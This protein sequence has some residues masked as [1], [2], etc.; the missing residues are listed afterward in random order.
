[1]LQKRNDSH[2]DE[3]TEGKYPWNAKRKAIGQ[4]PDFIDISI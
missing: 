4:M 3:W 2:T 1:M